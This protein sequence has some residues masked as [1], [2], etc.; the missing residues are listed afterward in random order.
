MNQSAFSVGAVLYTPASDSEVAGRIIGGVWPC[1]TS[2][3]LC[4]EDAIRDSALAEAEA[5]IL[6]AH[7]VYEQA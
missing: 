3:C 1:L 2:I 4:L 6:V 7:G 5:S